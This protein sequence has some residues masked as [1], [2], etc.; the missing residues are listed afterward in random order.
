MSDVEEPRLV[1]GGSLR[2]GRLWVVQFF[3]NP[4]VAGLFAAWLLIPE[5]KTWQLGLSV[6]LVAVIAAAALVLHAGTLNYFSD[7]FREQ[8]AAVT[9]SFGRAMRHF[10]AIVVCALVF[11]LVWALAGGFDRYHE[12]FPTYVRSMLTA[13]IRL[14]THLGPAS[15]ISHTLVFLLRHVACPP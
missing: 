9:T 4:I 8:S 15:R 11:Y 10:A 1:V 2:S 12:I 6:L 5:P 13:S 7:Q 14:P 3:V